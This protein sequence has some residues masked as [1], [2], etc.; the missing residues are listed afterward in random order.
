MFL[1]LLSDFRPD[2]ILVS[3]GFDAHRADMLASLSLETADYGTLAAR[4]ANAARAHCDGRLSL[5]LEGGYDLPILTDACAAVATAIEADPPGPQSDPAR[6]A[7][8][9]RIIAQTIAE[10]A[11]HWP[12]IF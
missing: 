9:E 10:I 4:V 6:S 12:G 2:H 7:K 3:A 5:F 11:P 8:G 1:P